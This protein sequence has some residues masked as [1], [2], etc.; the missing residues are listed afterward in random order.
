MLLDNKK[1]SEQNRKNALQLSGIFPNDNDN[2]YNFS[3]KYSECM[4]SLDFVAVIGNDNYSR[5]IRRYCPEAIPFRLW[6]LEPYHHPDNP[7]SEELNG[8]KV[9]VVHPFEKSIRKNYENRKKLFVGTNILPE[10]EL[11]TIKAEQNL[12]K[13]DSNW[14]ESLRLMQE[15]IS[16]VNFDISLVGCG[17]FGLPLASFIKTEL[18][19]TSIHLGGALQ[20]LF[21]IMGKRW[22]DYDHPTFKRF[23]NEYWTRPLPEETPCTYKDVE[24]GC[25]W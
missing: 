17:A 7:W 22:D 23:V 5:L 15:K 1:P 19:K 8:K 25:Y 18:Q 20:L 24:N 6:G 4:S 14:F 2:L 9:L 13:C 21:G 12:G 16:E 11:I 3:K 10:F